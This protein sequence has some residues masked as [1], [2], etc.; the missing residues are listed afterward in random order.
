MALAY[1]NAPTSW[2]IAVAISRT[3]PNSRRMGAKIT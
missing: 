3:I 2:V 1:P